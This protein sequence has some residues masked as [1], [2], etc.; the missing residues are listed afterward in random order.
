[1]TIENERLQDLNTNTKF[2]H[3]HTH[4]HKQNTITIRIQYFN[5]L[6]FGVIYCVLVLFIFIRVIDFRSVFTRISSRVL[7]VYVVPVCAFWYVI[8]FYFH[9]LRGKSRCHSLCLSSSLALC[10][11]PSFMCVS[12]FSFV[13][14]LF[15]AQDLKS[16]CG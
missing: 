15:G 8:Y 3:M 13:S 16:F 10:I 5:G 12:F 7:C 11:L 4:A 1:M 6:L 9:I 14:C 2:S